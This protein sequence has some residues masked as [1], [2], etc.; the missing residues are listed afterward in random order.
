MASVEPSVAR[1]ALAVRRNVAGGVNT[2]N[3]P[4]NAA[5]TAGGRGV[6][7]N[8]IRKLPVVIP[9]LLPVENSASVSSAKLPLSTT[10]LRT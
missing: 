3:V 8:V 9:V 6:R 2:R 1:S 4:R 10:P 7:R 5:Q